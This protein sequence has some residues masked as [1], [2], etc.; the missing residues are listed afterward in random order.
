MPDTNYEELVGV[1]GKPAVLEGRHPPLPG[2]KTTE[3][4]PVYSNS[5]SF[6]SAWK[7][8][9]AG[10]KRKN[11][12]D[13]PVE[14]EKKFAE[15]RRIE[16]MEMDKEPRKERMEERGR[17]RAEMERKELLKKELELAA[18]KERVQSKGRIKPLSAPEGV[19]STAEQPIPSDHG[20]KSSVTST[21]SPKQLKDEDDLSARLSNVSS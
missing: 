8:V 18:A 6:L 10:E 5:V 9:A 15:D 16:R 13:G 20:S 2:F 12:D 4:P 21:T 3:V 11:E 17:R 14:E 7:P 1:R 19:T